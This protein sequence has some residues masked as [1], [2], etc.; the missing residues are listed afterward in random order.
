MVSIISAKIKGK[1]LYYSHHFGVI[2]VVTLLLIFIYQAWPW[3]GWQFT[4][5]FWEHFTWLSPMYKLAIFESKN[6]IIGI[7]FLIPILYA[8][9]LLPLRVALVIILLSLARVLP[10]L[11]GLQIPYTTLIIN[12]FFLLSPFLVASFISINLRWH[13]EERRIFAEREAERQIYTSKVIESQENE[14]RRLAQELHDDTIQTL[15]VIAK[16][17]QNS[18]SS[19]D[20]SMVEMKTN[21]EYIKNT[22]LQAVEDVRRTCLDLRPSILDDLGLIPAL[23]WLVDHM[24]KDSDVNIRLEINGSHLEF[25]SKVALVIFRLV[26][27]AL[28][29][30]KRH[31]KATEAIVTLSSLENTLNLT[32][33]DNGQGFNL[34]K[35][36]QRFAAMGKLGLIG[37]QQRIKALNGTLRIRSGLGKGTLLSIKLPR[38]Q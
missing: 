28:N 1:N 5:G 33:E 3:R 7:L 30:V 35:G 12:L 2:I 37:M 21:A 10:L 18:I 9:I 19:D 14:R 15:I 11:L 17:A 4:Y 16:K 13:Q 32:I 6:H 20:E 34:P 8:A 25:S 26:Q 22:A 36:F 38:P 29:N 24:N 27:E 31:S 23:R